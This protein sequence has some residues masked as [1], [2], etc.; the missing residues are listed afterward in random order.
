MRIQQLSPEL[1]NQIAAGEV[2]ERPASVIKELV[3]NSIDAGA[4]NIELEIAQAGATTIRVSDDGNGIEKDDLKLALTAHATSKIGTLK[5]LMHIASLGFRGEALASIA[6]IARVTLQ[7]KVQHAEHAWT[8]HTRDRG[9]LSSPEPCALSKGTTIIVNDLFYNTP[10][11]RRFLRSPRTEWQYLEDMVKR[12]ALGYFSIGFSLRHNERIIF[13]LP[14]AR[15]QLGRE[16]RIR[17]LCGK[18]FLDNALAIDFNATNLQ[19]AGWVAEPGF[20]RNQVDLQYFY[21]NGRSI[22]DKVVMHAIRQVYQTL[23]PEGRQPCYILYLTVDPSSVD[24]NVHPTKHEVR[25]HQSRLVHD[26]IVQSLQQ[27]LFPSKQAITQENAVLPDDQ[28]HYE[29]TE[30][31]YSQTHSSSDIALKPTAKKISAA[32]S[33]SYTTANTNASSDGTTVKEQLKNYQRLV[34]PLTAIGSQEHNPFLLKVAESL[35]NQDSV[36]SLQE[37]ETAKQHI[38]IIGTLRNRVLLIETEQKLLLLDLHAAVRY[39]AGF[40]LAQYAQQPIL[41]QPLLIPACIQCASTTITHCLFYVKY[42]QKLGILI[43][44]LSS[45]SVRLSQLPQALKLFEPKAILRILLD[46]L[47]HQDVTQP[48]SDHAY[49]AVINNIISKADLKLDTISQVTLHQRILDFYCACEEQQRSLFCRSL[50]IDDL[51]SDSI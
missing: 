46:Y 47:V 40:T 25:F 16:Q 13:K 26:F 4:Q 11:R 9:E 20:S 23:L 17:K 37:Q 28:S 1:A 50:V 44:Q 5:D 35:S 39:Q 18:N 34:N 8:I 22:R 31:T 51:Y 19:L 49:Q 3:E 32:T 45:D 36:Q 41:S 24:V 14:P 48:W 33:V 6:A 15:D 30:V 10:V 43:E 21:L 12:M 29:I 38:K 7:S 2:I 42:L 27:A